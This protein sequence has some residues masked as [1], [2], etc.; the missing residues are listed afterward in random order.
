[1]IEMMTNYIAVKRDEAK[2]KTSGGLILSRK[3]D[4]WTGTVRHVGPGPRDEKTGEFQPMEV[5]AGD[6][7]LFM[8]H[9]TDKQ[10]VDG[11]ELD[12]MRIDKVLAIIE[13]EPCN[14]PA[15]IAA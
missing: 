7:I 12:L 1:M 2:E 3:E 9:G 10:D 13:G 15:D 6:R 11:E 8:R 14:T 4:Q 5:K